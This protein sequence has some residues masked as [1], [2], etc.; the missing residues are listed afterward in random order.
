MVC[1]GATLH[2]FLRPPDPANAWWRKGASCD[3][4]RTWLIWQAKSR[5]ASDWWQC[6]GT[7]AIWSIGRLR[8]QL[9]SVA[10]TTGMSASMNE[11]GVMS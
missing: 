9:A 6:D 4:E 8:F 7:W 11:S 10:R 1:D 2:S 5:W 3:V